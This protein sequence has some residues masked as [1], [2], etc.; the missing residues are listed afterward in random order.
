MHIR[1]NEDRDIKGAHV[2]RHGRAELIKVSR[3]QRRSRWDSLAPELLRR[4][5]LCKSIHQVLNTSRNI[6]R[7]LSGTSVASRVRRGIHVG[8]MRGYILQV[9]N[10]R[11]IANWL[12][13]VPYGRPRISARMRIRVASAALQQCQDAVVVKVS[14]VDD[15]QFVADLRRGTAARAEKWSRQCRRWRGETSRAR[16]GL[17]T[18]RTLSTTTIPSSLTLCKL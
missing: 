11:P 2:E 3:R 1:E 6:V 10:W 8:Q 17:A 15:E 7:I 18:A 12:R 13:C 14:V 16:R 9:L 5:D 4:A